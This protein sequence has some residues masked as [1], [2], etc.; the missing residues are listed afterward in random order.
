MINGRINILILVGAGI[1]S[2]ILGRMVHLQI[3]QGNDFAR[4]AFR[5]HYRR[6]SIKPRRGA[7]FDCRNRLLAA[8]LASDSLCADPKQISNVKVT[9]RQ[10]A[11]II[12]L[13]ENEIIS[14]LDKKGRRFTWLH[15]GITPRA[16]QLVRELAVP[17]LFF[18]RETLRIYPTGDLMSSIIGFSGIDGYGLEGLESTM[19]NSLAGSSG[20]E[21]QAFDALSRA[22]NADRICISEPVQGENLCLTLDSAI[23]YFASTEIKRIIDKENALWGAAVV[24]D[25][26]SGNI[27]ALASEPGFNPHQF[28]QSNPKNRKNRCVTQLFEP[29][30]TFK[31]VTLA[32]VLENQIFQLSDSIDCE[33]GSL[34]VGNSTFSDWKSFNDLSVRDVIVFSSNV[35]TIKTAQALGGNALYE[36]ADKIGFG[37]LVVPGVAG[38]ESGYI[39]KLPNWPS[40]AVASLSIGYG[41]A[42]TPLQLASVY[43]S[44]A[45]GGYQLIPSILPRSTDTPAIRIMNESTAKAV[46]EVLS[47][48][49][50]RG[51]GKL[52]SPKHYS[53][54]GKTGTARRY[55]HELAKYDSDRVTCVFAGF[56]PVNNPRISVCVV[57][58]DP[59]N[60]KWASKV[61]A[62]VFARIVNRTLLYLGEPPE[63]NT[64]A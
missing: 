1:L 24:L 45:N 31:A 4:Q 52:A 58:D 20:E 54:A 36:F 10:L 48:A 18:R 5:S 21:L 34:K 39:R 11:P 15:R 32:A 41:I 62:L 46:T 63:R 40:T 14:R 30:S 61:S 23:Q 38:I 25:I 53:A 55:N 7:I 59:K 44:F 9:A 27:L 29:G 35:G 12:S 13:S 37:H 60:H 2:L 22:Y 64:A 6:V 17:G 43:A 51:T 28:R 47:E 3:F 49:V 16:A 26:S 33:G 19:N 42:T 50:S 57:I 8:S 56:A